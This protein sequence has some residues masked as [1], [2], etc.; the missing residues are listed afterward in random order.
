MKKILLGTISLVVLASCISSPEDKAK[1]LI[2][3]EMKKVLYHAETYDPVET[4]VDS[5]FTPFDDPMFY[6]KTLQLYKLGMAIDEY[7]RKMKYEKSDMALYRD[8]LRIMFSNR[9]QEKY[10]QAK[11]NYESYLEKK[12]E[13]EVKAKALVSEI[14]KILD[15]KVLF[16]GF[17][18][19]H[20]Y[21]ANNNAGQTVFG[22]ME[23][24]FDK[25]ISKV[26]AAYDMDDKDYKAVQLLYKQMLGE[27]VTPE[28]DILYEEE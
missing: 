16:I 25:D 12:K 7:D 27:D 20:R 1:V 8:M 23:Y 28:D 13:T 10:N 17:K 15:K 21:R 2:R 22:D 26:V 11:E 9:D 4:R 19:R 24:L 5:A 6:D 18:A 3:E 14:K